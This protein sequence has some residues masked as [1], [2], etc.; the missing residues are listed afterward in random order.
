MRV[1]EVP[2][3]I[4]AFFLY[5]GDRRRNDEIDIEIMN[6]G[7]GDVWFT[8]WVAG[9]RTNHT[10]YTLP[11]DPGAGFHD[12]GIAWERNR[13]RF[14]VDGVQVEE[15]ATGVPK[16]AMY[17]MANAWWPTWLD[18]PVPLEPEQVVIDR[19]VY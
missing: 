6:D 19:I 16:D 2:G 7:S 17:V 5:E 11:F 3:S 14:L 12:Y 1:P 10:R 13:V 18:G 8:T 4:S 9:H 15:F